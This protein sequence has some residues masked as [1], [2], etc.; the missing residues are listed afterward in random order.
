ML[1]GVTR[2]HAQAARNVLPTE[3]ER[4]VETEALQ[5][6]SA[7]LLEAVAFGRDEETIARGER[8]LE[9]E[10]GRLGSRSEEAKR[11]LSE[12]CLFV[13]RA[14]LHRGDLARARA[15]IRQC[16][17]IVPDL[18]APASL[19]PPEVRDLVSQAEGDAALE[20]ARVMVPASEQADE[21]EATDR[22]PPVLAYVGA[23][24]GVVALTASWLLFAR[25][26]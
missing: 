23:G 2:A 10:R 21:L 11:A 5:R 7:E 24:T 14:L 26:W 12:I 19:H 3:G 8:V 25:R 17:R 4:S 16:W 22:A 18:S 1:S 15:Q 13:A 20:R 6:E 9:R